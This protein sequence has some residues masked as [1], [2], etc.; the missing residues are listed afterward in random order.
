MQVITV[1]KCNYH[2][3]K[4]RQKDQFQFRQVFQ[5]QRKYFESR[6]LQYLKYFLNSDL[7]VRGEKTT[8]FSKPRSKPVSSICMK[9]NCI[10]TSQF[11]SVVLKHYWHTNNT[12][13]NAPRKQRLKRLK[14]THRAI[15]Q[16][17]DQSPT[18]FS[19]PNF[20]EI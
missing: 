19:H 17:S 8:R 7:Q 5:N 18:S 20:T 9:S 12:I 6:G 10:L 2:L 13:L 1:S 14:W 4:I 3:S 15:W 16:N 11:M